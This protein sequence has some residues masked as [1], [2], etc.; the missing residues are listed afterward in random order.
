MTDDELTVWI[1]ELLGSFPGW[2]WRT[3][4]PY[5]A[6]NIAV[7][8]GALQTAPDRAVAVRIYTVGDDHRF[9]RER[10]AQ[11][12]YRGARNTPHDADRLASIVFAAVD[13][14]STVRGV[15]DIRRMSMA[16]LGADKNGREERT[17][18]YLITLENDQE[19]IS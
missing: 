4:G 12:Q 17:D 13:G 9:P 8:Y 5:S 3:S 2:E 10:R 6:T 7:F 18:N 16:R 15:S 14:L 1:C 19:V 11:L